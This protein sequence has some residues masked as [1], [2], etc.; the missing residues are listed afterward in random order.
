MIRVAFDSLMRVAALT[1]RRTV[2]DREE[3]IPTAEKCNPKESSGSYALLM[4]SSSFRGQKFTISAPKSDWSLAN[5]PSLIKSSYEPVVSTLWQIREKEP[6]HVCTR[7]LLENLPDQGRYI[8]FFHA[9]VTD[10]LLSSDRST[11]AKISSLVSGYE[12]MSPSSTSF[13]KKLFGK[14]RPTFL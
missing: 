5:N 2:Q 3:S 10:L 7:L 1:A 6:L 8:K 9:S 11:S 4:L 12:P 14:C 13:M